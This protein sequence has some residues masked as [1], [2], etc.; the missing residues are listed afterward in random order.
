METRMIR[1]GGCAKYWIHSTVSALARRSVNA[2]TSLRSQAGDCARLC[3]GPAILAMC[4]QV[5]VSLAAPST[6]DAGLFTHGVVEH[7]AGGI[8]TKVALRSDGSFVILS[9]NAPLVDNE[10]VAY[11]MQ[12]TPVGTIMG[13]FGFPGPIPVPCVIG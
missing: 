13:G 8:V 9:E 6:L 5:G 4:F 2:S 3:Y 7:L 12:R 10:R 1:I 11:L